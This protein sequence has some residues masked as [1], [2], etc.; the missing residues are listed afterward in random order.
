MA[1]ILTIPQLIETINKKENSEEINEYVKVLANKIYKVSKLPFFY[2]LP[3]NVISSIVQKV[4]FYE[5]KDPITLTKDIADKTSKYHEK[6]TV[7]LNFSDENFPS[8]QIENIIDIISN[9]I[10]ANS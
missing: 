1:K 7:S 9:S 4:A 3:I 2:S 8:F 10:V 5:E 6:E